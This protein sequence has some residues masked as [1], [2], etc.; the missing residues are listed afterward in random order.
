MFWLI[1]Q[2]ALL[3]KQANFHVSPK[4]S[5]TPARSAPSKRGWSRWAREIKHP[6]LAMRV[7]VEITR[8][9][10]AVLSAPVASCNSAGVAL[11]VCRRR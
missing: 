9:A 1:W 10:Q 2:A 11:P 8:K 4:F 3:R 5:L 6:H 7:L